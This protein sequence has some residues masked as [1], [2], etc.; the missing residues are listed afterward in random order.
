MNYYTYYDS[1]FANLFVEIGTILII[2]LIAFAI[3]TIIANWKI[4]KKAGKG[5]WE[6]IVPI[7]GY[8]VLNE[9]AGLEW[10]WFLLT[11]ID[12]I[13]SLLGLD[14]LS[15]IANL[16]S[17]FANFNIYYNIAIKFNK[18]KS[19]AICAGIFSGI[20]T[21]IFGFSKN[22]VYNANIPVSKNGIFGTPKNNVNNNNN[23]YVQSNTT[24]SAETIDKNNVN[25]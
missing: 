19:Y 23:G 24:Q 1:K 18:N 4:Y 15:A 21:L 11:M 2:L 14:D 16:V 25:Q 8:W 10:W 22:E 20:F 17:L 12:D 6:C 3:V 7:Y 13:V 9:I 5:G